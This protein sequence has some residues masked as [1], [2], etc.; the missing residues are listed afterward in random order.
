MYFESLHW[1][2]QSLRQSLRYPFKEEIGTRTLLVGGTAVMIAALVQG[3]LISTLLEGVPVGADVQYTDDQLVY[4][5]RVQVLTSLVFLLLMAPVY[6]YLLRMLQRL[7]SP[8]SPT[9][10]SGLG[11]LAGKGLKLS[12][13]GTLFT[14]LPQ[15]LTQSAFGSWAIDLS[16]VIGAIV[17]PEVAG[18]VIGLLN[19]LIVAYLFPAV[20]T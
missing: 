19:G 2:G 20:L 6:G 15:S 11:S 16:L 12:F 5:Y 13:I 3:I 17:T 10:S 9:A 14:L 18:V 7:L 8:N 1:I 4:I